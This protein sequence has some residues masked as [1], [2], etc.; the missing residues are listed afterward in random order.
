MIHARSLTGLR[1]QVVSTCRRSLRT[2]FEKRKPINEAAGHKPNGTNF[3]EQLSTIVQKTSKNSWDN[4]STFDKVSGIG[5]KPS[6]LRMPM[7]GR[8]PDGS[9]RSAT[10][11]QNTY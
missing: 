4:C 2:C 7:F 10:D 8:S 9:R 1:E 3:V 5:R 6:G 11:F